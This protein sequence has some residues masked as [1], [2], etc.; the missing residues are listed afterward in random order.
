MAQLAKRLTLDF[1][2]GY[3]LTIPEI[4][5]CV[6]FC[7]DSTESTWDSLSPPSPTLPPSCSLSLSLS[8]NKYIKLKKEIT[9]IRNLHPWCLPKVKSLS[10]ELHVCVGG[11]RGAFEKEK[12]LGLRR[13]EFLAR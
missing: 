8:Q 4:E 10:K 5:S 2:S 1:G 7:A 9:C 12:S 13:M 3:A 6:G 11:N